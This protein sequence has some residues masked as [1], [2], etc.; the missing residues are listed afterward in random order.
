MDYPLPEYLVEKAV[1]EALAE[2]LGLAG[3]ITTD[4]IIPEDAR[5]AAAIVVREPGRIAG[6]DLAEA[7]FR[8]LDPGVKF[9]RLLDDG[10]AAEAG[11]TIARV[12]GKT[13]ALLT[14]ERT[15]LNFFGRLC[16]IATLT[17]AFV[18]KVEGTGAR[19]AD[20]RKTTPGLRAF[21]KY[22]VRCGGGANHR[23]G[24]HD[25]VLVKDNHIAA[26]GGL[27]SAL[28]RLRARAG[29]MVKIEVEVDTLD[30]L[31]DALQFPIDAVLLDNMDVPTLR[32]AVALAQGKVLTEASGGVNLETVAAIA[33]T[34]VDLISVG[35]LTHSPRNLDSSLEWTP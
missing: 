12:E 2:D 9:E 23:F 25:A 13:R 7:A 10:A 15:A 35:A 4:P 26:A 17:A 16:G 5:G 14:G 1:R 3:D 29:H 22:A 21:E 19:I 6:L 30:Q 33:E 31:R 11:A 27:G 20:T 8:A 18:A 24:L 32:E 34:G 28:E